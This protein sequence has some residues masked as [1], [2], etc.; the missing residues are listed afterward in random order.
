[1]GTFNILRSRRNKEQSLRN[2]TGWM[3][4]NSWL[5]FWSFKGFYWPKSETKTMY[6]KS[7]SD[8]SVWYTINRA[9]R[10]GEVFTDILAGFTFN[11]KVLCLP[12]IVLLN[13]TFWPWNSGLL[14]VYVQAFQTDPF[15]LLCCFVW[16]LQEG[17]SLR[18]ETSCSIKRLLEDEELCCC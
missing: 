3:T 13:T 6:K 2:I 9:D 14:R 12:A 18:V 15:I 1:M 16:V 11:D 7:E 8:I 4:Y 5:A 17:P 10:K